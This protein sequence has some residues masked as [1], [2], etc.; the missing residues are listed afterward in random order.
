MKKAIGIAILAILTIFMMIGLASAVVIKN[1][2]TE[3]LIPGDSARI[4][5]VVENI[6]DDDIEDVSL[7]LDLTGLPLSSI[8]STEDII[9]DIESDDEEDFGFIIR[10]SNN[11]IPGDYNIP[12]TL[13]YKNL[14]TPKTGTI[15]ITISANADLTFSID[16]ENP[17]I[18]R[19]GKIS[20]KIVNK[21]MADAR[22]VSLRILP[23]GYILLSR[24]DIYIGEINSDDFETENFDVVFNSANPLLTAIVEYT[25]FD[26]SVISKN[27]N[28]PVTVYSEEKA[29]ELGIIKKSN[30][31]L[32]LGIAVGIIL[33]WIIWKRIAK[34]RKRKLVEGR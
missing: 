30:A 12:Y 27:V 23:S 33:I 24:S 7:S 34:R 22:F 20:L 28:I 13:T 1:V 25:D 3:T 9:P 16:S 17:V 31:K 10:A 8:G 21:G 2:D 26:N 18:G 32:Y 14:T 6:L 29:I 4:K 15:G 5:I 11:A 19:Q